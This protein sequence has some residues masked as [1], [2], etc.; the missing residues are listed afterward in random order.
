[1][2]TA[3]LQHAPARRTR[4]GRAEF[5]AAG[6]THALPPIGA[7]EGPPLP[8]G[9]TLHPD[10]GC[11]V[12]DALVIALFAHPGHMRAVTGAGPSAAPG[13]SAAPGPSAAPGSGESRGLAYARS[14]EAR[15]WLQTIPAEDR[16]IARADARALEQT[17][18]AE[19]SN[20]LPLLCAMV[21]KSTDYSDF[22][23]RVRAG[24][25]QFKKL[26][27]TLNTSQSLFLAGDRVN[28][29]KFRDKVPALIPECVRQSL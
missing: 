12:H 23:E 16:N 24:R 4:P 9:W 15:A 21:E 1:M 3:L 20:F 7:P 28:A 22:M 25:R 13:A 19:D 8:P 18:P 2:S 5:E 10:T 26:V 14:A 27:L 11:Y 6:L 29:V 17:L